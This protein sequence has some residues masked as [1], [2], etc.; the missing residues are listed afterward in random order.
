MH[1]IYWSKV[2]SETQS[3]TDPAHS[4]PISCTV[5][6]GKISFYSW[7]VAV[8]STEFTQKKWRSSAII[9]NTLRYGSV[10]DTVHHIT[11]AC[12]QASGIAI[13]V[14]GTIGQYENL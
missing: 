14:T 3:F 6:T 4:P 13:P 2:A 9:L 12:Y 5:T 11:R 10:Q 1:R 7:L 8:N